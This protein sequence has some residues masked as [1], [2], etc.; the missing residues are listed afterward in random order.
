[1]NAS[2]RNDSPEPST[3]AD[4]AA[5][6][7][8][9][10]WSII[11]LAAD[12]SLEGTAALESL[13]AAYWRPV[14]AYL[15]RKGYSPADA[16]DL[17]QEFFFRLIRQRSFA[18]A[19]PRRGRFRS[20][21]LGALSHFLADQWD[22][23]QAAKRGGGNL[24]ISLDAEAEKSYQTQVPATLATD[25]VFAQQWAWTL[26]NNALERLAS[27][28]A[29]DGKA[30]QFE[31]L[32]PYLTEEPHALA[33]Q[34]LSAKLGASRNTIAKTIQRLRE[35]FRLMVRQAA[36]ETVASPADLEDELRQLF[37]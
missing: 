13:C 15:R 32:K 19:D 33:Y 10:H 22:R 9:T 7:T 31:L 25:Q 37:A 26:V 21:L 20:F 36:L 3:S 4:S 2:F 16:K 28:Q 17:T 29:V 34:D 6:F 11:M 1:M 23:A 24:V 12:N 5:N 18:S 8:R 27:A 35:R 14:Y 30:L